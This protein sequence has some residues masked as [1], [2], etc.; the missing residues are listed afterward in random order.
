M[1]C[2]KF[3][4]SQRVVARRQCK[5][6]TDAYV[7]LIAWLIKVAKHPG[8]ANLIP[9]DEYL[10]PIMLDQEA[11]EQNTDESQNPVVED[12]FGGGTYTFTSSQVFNYQLS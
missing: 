11:T 8:Y 3:T 1:L 5:L 12:Q 7:A 2:G 10:D 9:P 6:N 4:R